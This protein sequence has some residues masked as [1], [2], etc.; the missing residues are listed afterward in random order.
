MAAGAIVGSARA[1]FR[2]FA[3]QW[4]RLGWSAN[5]MINRA[6]EMGIGFRRSEMLAITRAATGLEKLEKAVRATAGDALFPKY[7]MVEADFR[8]ARRYLIHGVIRY[9]D[10]ETGEETVDHISFYDN[11]RKTKDQWVSDWFDRSAWSDSVE[12][13]AI[14]GLEIVSVQHKPGWGY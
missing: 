9:T 13:V 4:V 8:A 10:P 6:R 2:S 11:T 1:V 7:A 14:H 5:Q 3:P 12:M